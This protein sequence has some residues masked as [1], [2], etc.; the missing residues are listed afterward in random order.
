MKIKDIQEG[1]INTNCRE[2]TGITVGLLDGLIAQIRIVRN[3][4]LDDKAI[5]EVFKDLAADE[6]F[7][8][9]YK[10]VNKYRSK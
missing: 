5:V 3:R 10:K 7:E 2:E 1:T 4:N 8:W 9:L 6:D